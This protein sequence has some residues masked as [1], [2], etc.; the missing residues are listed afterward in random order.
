MFAQ[1]TYLVETP[2]LQS[3]YS[4]ELA[5]SHEGFK[6]LCYNISLQTLK[7]KMGNGRDIHHIKRTA[8]LDFRDNG[9]VYNTCIDGYKKKKISLFIK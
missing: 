9:R 8:V 1:A 6:H 4:K 7:C 2:W 5:K 3:I